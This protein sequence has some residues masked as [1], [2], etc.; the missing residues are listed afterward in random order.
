MPHVFVCRGEGV[1]FLRLETGKLGPREETHLQETQK[2]HQG[3]ARPLLISFP[4]G[5]LLDCCFLLRGPS[6]DE[7][8]EMP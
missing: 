3:G 4:F 2:Q 6:A 8:W 1:F 7:M 5:S